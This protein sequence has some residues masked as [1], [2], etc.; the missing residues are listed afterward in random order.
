MIIVDEPYVSDILIDTLQQYQF[1]VLKTG[2]AQRLLPETG[3]NFID[4]HQALTHMKSYR[5]PRL[6]TSSENSIDWI[7]KNLDFTGLPVKVNVFKNKV[8]FRKLISGIYPDFFYRGISLDEIDDLNVDNLPYP[9]II[10]P[11]VG[12]FGL[13]VYKVNDRK[14]WDAVKIL[15]KK[16]VSIISDTYPKEVLNTGQFIIEENIEGDEFAFDAYYNSDGEPVVL[17]VLNHL[18]STGESTN[19]RIYMT[20]KAIVDANVDRFEEFL[21]KMGTLVNLKNFPLHVEVRIDKDGKIMPIEVNPLRF[22]GWCTSAD[23]SF[24]AT[25]LNEYECFFNSRRPDW[26][27]LF[28]GRGDKIFSIIILDNST[29]VEAGKIKS[30]DYEK[31]LEGFEHPLELRKADVVRYHLFGFLFT[32]TRSDHFVELEQILHSNLREFITV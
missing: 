24:M 10:K 13:G 5:N 31:L 18:F 32:Q 30:F 11:S 29:G 19:D 6:Y 20:S 23:L 26:E 1:P 7:V 25:G 12:F 8:D 15:L 28:K 17:C 9:F 22:G 14:N 3:I 21:R 2:T 16:E 4:E 27:A